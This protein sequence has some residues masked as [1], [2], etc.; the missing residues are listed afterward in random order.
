MQQAIAL[1][2]LAILI[3]IF[4]KQK[5][6]EKQSPDWVVVYCE[7][8]VKFE[9]K[10]PHSSRILWKHT[11]NV[12]S[13]MGSFAAYIVAILYHMIVGYIYYDVGP[14][15][16]PII[17]QFLFFSRHSFY[18]FVLN[19]IETMCSPTLRKSFINVLMWNN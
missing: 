17:G 12:V 9:K 10:K 16:P 11:R 3:S 13:P 15:G 1:L 14:S 6:L 19:F 2:N 5:Q 4:L 18:F 8:G 7:N